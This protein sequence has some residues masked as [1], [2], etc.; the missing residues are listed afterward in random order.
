MKKVA[1]LGLTGWE[2]YGE[3]F[4]AK[5]VDYLVGEKYETHFVDFR[6]HKKNLNYLLFGML[7]VLHNIL[8]FKKHTHFLTYL[9]VQC[10]CRHY[11]RK[12]L[13]GCD[14]LI[15]ACGSFKYGTQKL[16]AYYSVAIEVASK[17]NIPVMFNA[18]NIQ[19]FD[20]NDWRCRCLKKH[21]NYPCVKVFTTRDG[22]YGLSKLKRDYLENEEIY[23][24]AVGDPAFW[25]PENYKITKSKSPYKIGINLIRGSI[26]C[27]Y[28]Y[29][30]TEEQLINFYCDLIMKLENL[31]EEWELFT[32]G[33]EV[34]CL[35]G[36]KVLRKLNRMDIPIRV[37]QA[38]FELVEMI[39]GYKAIFGI[40]L[41]ACICAY[42]LNV[43]LVGAIWDEKL[44]RFA[45]ITGLKDYF[46]EENDMKADVVYERLQNALS[47]VYD[48]RL[49]TQWKDKTKTTIQHFLEEY[50]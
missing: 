22:A 5:T 36:E 42:S 41:H 1:L 48:E 18:M 37:P 23:T 15:F 34:D 49:K 31:G 11:F 30:M 39:S 3:Q 50:A 8:P 40:R 25:I 38:D 12:G 21:V 46:L 28:G 35:L 44:A 45:E 9:S 14:A 7:T 16:W 27:D 10:L 26:F 2:N 33:L 6:P 43:P 13:T 19:D 4:L 24:E 17:M 32:N 20:G 29:Q 47:F